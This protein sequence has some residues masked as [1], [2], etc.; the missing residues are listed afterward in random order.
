MLDNIALLSLGD[1][2]YSPY[3]FLPN[4]NL[5]FN[6]WDKIPANPALGAVWGPSAYSLQPADME[7]THIAS[8]LLG[9]DFFRLNA[10]IMDVPTVVAAYIAR[11]PSYR[12]WLLRHIEEATQTE[13]SEAHVAGA[14]R[15]VRSDEWLG[16]R[17]SK[18]T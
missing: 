2:T 5:G 12:T 15:F 6:T 14:L 4:N 17:G 18:S 8:E 11:W 3:H 7:A 9:P 10:P 1:G 13:L 16:E